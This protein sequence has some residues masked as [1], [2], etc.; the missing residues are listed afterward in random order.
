MY[1]TVSYA[2]RLWVTVDNLK[3]LTFVPLKYEVLKGFSFILA[4]IHSKV[5]LVQTSFTL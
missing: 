3:S 5:L 2:K 1:F 4:D